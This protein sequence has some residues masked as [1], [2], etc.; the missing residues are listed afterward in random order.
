MASKVTLTVTKGRLQGK[1]Y[2]FNERNICLIG[3]GKECGLVLP[4]DQFHRT[5]SRFHCLLDVNPPVLI[6]RDFGSLNGTYVNGKKIGQR[7]PN[8]TPKQG[9]RNKYPEHE[10]QTGDFIKLGNTVLGVEV[11]VDP[12]YASLQQ[13]RS[14]QPQNGT[15]KMRQSQYREA[16]EHLLKQGVSKHPN[17]SPIKGYKILEELG[18]GAFGSVYLALNQVSG[19]LVA[20]KVMLPEVV[21][22]PDHVKR[23]LREM[24]L[25]KSLKHKNVVRFL[26]YGHSGETFYFTLEYCEGGSVD[27]L[28]KEKQGPLAIDEA[29]PIILE[30]LDGLEY[31]HERGVVHRDLK[32]GNLFLTQKGGSRIAK[33]GDYGLSRAF[34]QA[35]L[36]GPTMTGTI[37]GTPLYMP[38]QQ[39]INFK[40]AKPEVDV[41]A[42]AASLY[43][44]LTGTSPREFSAKPDPFLVV[45]QTDAV[46][47]RKR[48]GSIPKRLAEVIDLALVDNPEITFK[49]A[50]AFKHALEKAIS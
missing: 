31:A 15:P 11:E 30:I 2:S 16:I 14:K 47:I 13:Q 10:L 33:V 7:L 39:L 12:L 41:W 27:N 34:D 44:L 49:T 18:M 4:N 25:T 1:S 23:F 9:A 45:L 29:V 26:D 28:L 50:K 8:Q 35:G 48:N 32:P 42:A 46:P 43:M 5:I 36:A 3:R 22:H 6:L 20:L 19:E 21:D 38:R 24:K 17:L 40:H 37:G